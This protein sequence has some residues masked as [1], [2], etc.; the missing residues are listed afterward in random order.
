MLVADRLDLLAARHDESRAVRVVG[1]L[2][3]A[4]PSQA[5][6]PQRHRAPV[7]HQGR[8]L[9]AAVEI[10]RLEVLIEIE[11]QPAH[12]VL[13]LDRDAR[14]LAV[15]HHGPALEVVNRA[16]AAVGADREHARARVHRHDHPELGRGAADALEQLV[17]HLARHHGDVEFA[18]LEPGHVFGSALGRHLADLERRIDGT[19]RVEK[20]QR[21][22]LEAAAFGRRAELRN[23]ISAHDAREP[24]LRS[25]SASNVRRLI[26]CMK[27]LVRFKRS[28]SLNASCHGRMPGASIF[29]PRARSRRYT[30]SAMYCGES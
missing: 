14:A 17:R 8:P 11:T 29:R 21:I 6:A 13:R 3:E 24:A 28:T 15:P 25:A 19:H 1:H 5:A 26:V 7:Q 20:R 18:R 27:S 9:G 30:S 16:I 10:D 2:D 12:H 4:R 23:F 22:D